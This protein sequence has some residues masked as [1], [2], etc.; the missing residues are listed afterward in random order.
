MMTFKFLKAQCGDS[1]LISF[2]D[3][4]GIPRNILIDGGMDQTW[5]DPIFADGDLKKE[6]TRIR[7]NGEKIDLL[8]L[9]HID[10]DHICGL[11]KWFEMDDKAYK[12]I[13]NVW[14]NSGKL[15]AKELKKP[16]NPDL[17]LNLKISN[18]TYT[19]VS[20]ALNFEEYLLNNDIWK[21]EL[22]KYGYLFEEYGIKISVLSPD[23]SQL[24]KLLEKFKKETKDDIAYTGGEK[25]D[26]DSNL[27]DLISEESQ[28][29]Y[30]FKQDA[31]PSNGSSI[32]FV[33]NIDDKNFLFLGD[34]HPKGII[35]ALA[36]E[37]FSKDNPLKVEFMKL[38][39]H[40]S[41]AN[42][43]KELLEMISTNNYIISTDASSHGHPN[44][45]T[46]ARILSNNPRAVFHFNHENVFEEV[47]TKND[48]KDFKIHKRLTSQLSY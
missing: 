37:G 8:I 41:K 45:R 39:H 46:L 44:K 23:R 17:Q 25:R 35:K 4:T 10:N 19:G 3:K 33:L 1:F 32:S 6:I 38:S 36:K 16:E 40:G 12:L 47:F 11:L 13:T 24:K 30:K 21:Q 34:C 43:C 31:S 48:F 2:T 27:S 7:D 29:G 18:D 22:I 14:F 42:T 26:W 20:E 9:T 5:E 15:I 28:P